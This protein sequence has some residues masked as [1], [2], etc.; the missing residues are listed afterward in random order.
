MTQ[1]LLGIVENLSKEE[2]LKIVKAEL[3]DQ[4]EKLE[5]HE[6]LL[7]NKED[8]I[9]ADVAITYTKGNIRLLEITLDSLNNQ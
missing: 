4:R 2:A 7:Q 1:L 9:S 5:K 8:I 6:K 3:K